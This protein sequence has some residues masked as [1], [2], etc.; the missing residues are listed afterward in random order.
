MARGNRAPVS[1]SLHRPPSS[2]FS[3]YE[4]AAS[5]GLGTRA[6]QRLATLRRTSTFDA[7]DR[8]LLPKLTRLR[9]PVLVGSQCGPSGLRPRRRDGFWDPPLD[10][11]RRAITSPSCLRF[12]VPQ[13][14]LWGAPDVRDVLFPARPM[15]PTSDAPVAS[16]VPVLGGLSHPRFHVGPPGLEL[17]RIA[18]R[19]HV[20]DDR[21]GRPVVRLPSIGAISHERGS[22]LT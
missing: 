20:T 12:G 15:R 1:P 3:S 22:R 14:P 8:C 6:T 21:K 10:R 7:S 19:R 2:G 17:P 5:F 13:S 16:P 9:A 4:V 18:F 11:G